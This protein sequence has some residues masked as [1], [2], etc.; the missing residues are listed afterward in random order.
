MSFE[1]K[2]LVVSTAAASITVPTAGN[3]A[4]VNVQGSPI[5]MGL[6]EPF[7]TIT[8][9]DVDGDGDAEFSLRRD[10]S[11][12]YNHV[13]MTSGGQNGDGFINNLG[14]NRV[15]MRN[16][17]KSIVVSEILPSGYYW[18]EKNS[19]FNGRNFLYVQSGGT[20]LLFPQVNQGNHDINGDNYVGFRFDSGAGTQYGWARITYNAV[21]IPNSSVT[22][23]EWTYS[24]T[25]GESVH[26]P[27][28]SDDVEPVPLP[29]SALPALTMLAMGAAGMRAMRKRK[30]AC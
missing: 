22:I 12:S 1:K 6:S 15:N 9:W 30:Q 3:A 27:T 11:S 7:G 17:P 14:D 21:G 29:S 19:L 8:P 28:R 25:P 4:L 18:G 24:D 20:L 2:L 23:E 10:G 5:T 26:I 13:Y 16:L